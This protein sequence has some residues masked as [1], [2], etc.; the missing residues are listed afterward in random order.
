MLVSVQVLSAAISLRLVTDCI[1]YARSR[2]LQVAAAVVDPWG[3][4]IAFLRTDGVIPPAVEFATDK[5]YTAATLRR[6]TEAFFERADSSPSLRLGLTTRSRL[7]VW[8]GGLPLFAAGECVGGL[9]VSGARDVEDVECAKA[10]IR[11]A[12]LAWEP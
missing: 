3:H 10:A 7:M 5:A 6:S 2:S 11:A 12:G 4:L 9:G 8:S 1:E